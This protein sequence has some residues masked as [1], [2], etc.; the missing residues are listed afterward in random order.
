MIDLLPWIFFIVIVKM[1]EELYDKGPS[2]PLSL[3]SR[4]RHVTPGTTAIMS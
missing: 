3:A 1:R 2:Q 4:P